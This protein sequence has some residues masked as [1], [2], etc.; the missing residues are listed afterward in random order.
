MALDGF[1]RVE[2]GEILLNTMLKIVQRRG[3]D[4]ELPLQGGAHLSFHMVDLPQ[5][6]HALANDT[7]RLVQMGMALMNRAGMEGGES[8]AGRGR[9]DRGTHLEGLV[10]KMTSATSATGMRAVEV[11]VTD[12]REVAGQCR[13]GRCRLLGS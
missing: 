4:V 9:R 3:I 13:N 5:C 11:N 6:K 8:V 12:E 2:H 10:G 1:R 7:P